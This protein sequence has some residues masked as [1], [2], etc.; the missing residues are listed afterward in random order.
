MKE[1]S[2]RRDFM[3]GMMRGG[4]VGGVIGGAVALVKRNGIDRSAHACTS[5]GICS[6]CARATDC[7]LPAAASRRMKKT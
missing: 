3:R 4:I 6:G 2:S 1:Q 7:V 5:G